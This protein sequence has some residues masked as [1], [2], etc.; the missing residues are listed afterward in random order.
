MKYSIFV[1]V[2]LAGCLSTGPLF[3]EP[4]ATPGQVPDS[5]KDAKPAG[6]A[7]PSALPLNDYERVLYDFLFHRKYQQLGWAVDKSVRDT[8]PFL[9]L[10]NYGTHPAVRIYYSPEI[11]TWLVNG[12]VGAPADGAMII[13]EMFAPPAVQY[14]ELKKH[15]ALASDPRK[16][17]HELNRLLSAWTVLVKDSSVSKDGWFWAGPGAPKPGVS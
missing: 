16:Y 2:L 7:L 4:A 3:A 1:G 10:N 5:L 14:E 17:E 11:I 9:N 13:K 6:L 15:A 8:G 12:R